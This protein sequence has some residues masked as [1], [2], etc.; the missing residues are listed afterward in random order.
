MANSETVR[1][2]PRT[3]MARAETVMGRWNCHGKLCCKGNP[4]NCQRKLSWGG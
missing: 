3:V 2:I 1:A 4:P